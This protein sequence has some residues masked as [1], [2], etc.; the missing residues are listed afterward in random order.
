MTTYIAFLEQID[1]KFKNKYM[2]VI[3]IEKA[4]GKYNSR[5]VLLFKCQNIVLMDGWKNLPT[6]GVI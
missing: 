5:K 2:N 3:F 6:T 4:R 1:D